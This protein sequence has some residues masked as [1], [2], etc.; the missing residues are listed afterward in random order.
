MVIWSICNE[1]LCNSADS[2]N[3]AIAMKDL[4]HALDPLGNRPVSANQV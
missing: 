3:D 4:M 1:V 2:V